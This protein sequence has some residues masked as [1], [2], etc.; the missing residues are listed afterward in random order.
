MV[1]ACA[2]NTD[3]GAAT[4]PACRSALAPRWRSHGCRSRSTITR[5]TCP[6]VRQKVRRTVLAS[7][8]ERRTESKGCS[9][10]KLLHRGAPRILVRHARRKASNTTRAIATHDRSRL[11]DVVTLGLTM[12]CADSQNGRQFDTWRIEFVRF[13]SRSEC[14]VGTCGGAMSK[15]CWDLFFPSYRPSAFR[16]KADPHGGTRGCFCPPR[17]G[18][19]ST[20]RR[21]RGLVEQH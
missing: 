10:A 5:R 13:A 15:L 20:A 2:S 12:A 11:A 17:S 9:H 6:D 4:P 1:V 8:G 19:P 14:I 21:S 3:T 7:H 16:H 18:L